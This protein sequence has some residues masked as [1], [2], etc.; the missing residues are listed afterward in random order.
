MRKMYN[1]KMSGIT[2][3]ILKISFF[4][5]NIDNKFRDWYLSV[6]I[7]KESSLVEDVFV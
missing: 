3:R 6:L 5:K 4:S 2:C 7:F 1:I